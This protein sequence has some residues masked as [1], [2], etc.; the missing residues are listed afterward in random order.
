M[1]AHRIYLSE[2][3]KQATKHLVTAQ[4][5]DLFTYPHHKLSVT[6]DHRGLVELKGNQSIDIIKAKSLF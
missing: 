4:Q 3:N 2:S 6:P 1:S 5:E